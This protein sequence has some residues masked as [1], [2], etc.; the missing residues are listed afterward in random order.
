MMCFMHTSQAQVF[1]I[2]HIM[3]DISVTPVGNSQVSVDYDIFGPNTAVLTQV[4][5]DGLTVVYSDMVSGGDSVSTVFT[6]PIKN[7]T[8][9]EVNI[10]CELRLV[11]GNLIKEDF[12]V[13]VF[14]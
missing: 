12:T 1:Q 9:R 10:S 5:L 4:K 6:V 11:N 8:P 7:S 14:P 2:A 13:T 3:T